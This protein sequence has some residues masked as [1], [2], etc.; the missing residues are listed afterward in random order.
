MYFNLFKISIHYKNEILN[1]HASEKDGLGWQR[2]VEEETKALGITKSG[3]KH[4]HVKL[5]FFFH[6]SYR[7]NLGIAEGRGRNMSTK[8]I[9]YM[10]SK[11]SKCSY[12][13]IHGYVS[14]W[15][16]VHHH[17]LYMEVDFKAFKVS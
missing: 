7:G 4:F 12:S 5:H 15:R 8:R 11:F 3:R 17:C 6:S 14:V 10:H 2:N 9:S 13:W 1:C 16:L